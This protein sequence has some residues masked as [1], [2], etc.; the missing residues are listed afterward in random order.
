LIKKCDIG[1]KTPKEANVSGIGD[2]QRKNA[3]KRH[4]KNVGHDHQHFFEGVLIFWI[5]NKKC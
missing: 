1:F 2:T 4:E 5:Q 3:T